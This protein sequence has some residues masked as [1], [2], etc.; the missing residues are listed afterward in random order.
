MA[1][2]LM[3]V[4]ED[5]YKGLLSTAK[6]TK[7]SSNSHDL[8]EVGRLDYADKAI[9]REL[10]T[11]RSS[12]PFKKRLIR[13]KIFHKGQ[14]MPK[15]GTTISTKKILYDQALRRYLRLRD[16]AKNRPVK[17]ELVPSGAKVLI[18]SGKNAGAQGG[19]YNDQ[20]DFEDYWFDDSYIPRFEKSEVNSEGTPVDPMREAFVTPQFSSR[21][22]R[23]AAPFMHMQENEKNEMKNQ[24]KQYLLNNA[25][26]FPITKDGL[27]VKTSIKAKT[28]IKNSNLD[29]AIERI[30][31][32]TLENLPS[33]AG[34]TALRNSLLNNHYTNNLISEAQKR[35]V[36]FGQYYQDFSNLFNFES[37]PLKP[38][39]SSAKFQRGKGNCCKNTDNFRPSKWIMRKNKKF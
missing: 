13:R 33:P 23:L 31:F 29:E 1:R 39:S 17:V 10:K 21:G 34:T 14:I 19:I 2:R 35:R 11:R 25:D 36:P 16:E 7:I 27:H 15:K 18:K 12:K 24:L 38:S 8:A 37:D 20:G 9:N 30:L 3:V 22:R 32:P 5:M 26:K 4:P 6:T 28:Y